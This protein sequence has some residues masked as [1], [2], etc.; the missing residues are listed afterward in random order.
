MIY[1]YLTLSTLLFSWLFAWYEYL[2]WLEKWK[3]DET[4]DYYAY[5]T[6]SAKW[7]R[8]SAGYRGSA[9]LMGMALAQ[10]TDSILNFILA[11][12]LIVT[13]H[14]LFGNGIQN[15][16]K[17]R[18]FFAVSGESESDT[19][20]YSTWWIAAG[21]K[22]TGTTNM[23]YSTDGITWNDMSDAAGIDIYSIQIF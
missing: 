11:G 17:G 15:L 14:F 16:Y 23:A 3:I 2:R 19:E 9:I 13:I 5:L 1:L 22:G 12:A 21:R 20:A 8:V 10:F 18:A 6:N 7:H 4:K